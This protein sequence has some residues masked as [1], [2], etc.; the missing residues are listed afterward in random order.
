M[1]TT[2]YF[3]TIRSERVLQID[4]EYI[5]I[6]FSTLIDRKERK[7]LSSKHKKEDL[8]LHEN[9]IDDNTNVHFLQLL[10]NC[11]KKK[12]TCIV[13]FISK[14]IDTDSEENNIYFNINE[15]QEDLSKH[16]E[17][18]CSFNKKKSI[19]RKIT[20]HNIIEC[21]TLIDGERIQQETITTQLSNLNNCC[22]LRFN[23][24]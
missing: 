21:V 23:I 14:Q 24:Q 22:N 17:Q 18:I 3:C 13:I 5:V 19:N 7:K 16:I 20:E 9:S 12:E 6:R 8:N 2:S 11:I 15:Q 1:E 10:L 4:G